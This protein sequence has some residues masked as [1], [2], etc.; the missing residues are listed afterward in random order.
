MKLTNGQC[1]CGT[2]KFKFHA[3]EL[4]AYQCHCSICRKA[5]GSAYSTTLM[6]KKDSF[7]WVSGKDQISSYS[8]ENGYKNNFCSCCGSP[9]P[10]LFR[11]YPLYSVPVGSLEDKN[12]IEIKVQIFCGSKASWEKE[13]IGKIQFEEMPALNEMLGLLHV[14][15]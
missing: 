15:V 12:H 1:S 7:E 5:T 14:Q 10:N 6:A 11:D 4:T 2:V 9:V 13:V 3:D 8:K